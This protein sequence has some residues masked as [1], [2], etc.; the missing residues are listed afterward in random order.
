MSRGSDGRSISPVWCRHI[1]RWHTGTPGILRAGERERER[2]YRT[3]I[4][5]FFNVAVPV[6]SSLC[7]L[8]IF[9]CRRRRRRRIYFP[10]LFISLLPT[11]RRFDK[12]QSS[13]KLEVSGFCRSL[14]LS[15]IPPVSDTHKLRTDYRFIISI[16]DTPVSVCAYVRRRELSK[17][18]SDRRECVH[19]ERFVIN[20]VYRMIAV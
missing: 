19:T 11:R 18:R 7:N 6:L 13:E 14:L 16:S 12:W 9:S 4:N 1:W 15:E 5:R 3:C 20:A 10:V 17:C 8:Y 2:E